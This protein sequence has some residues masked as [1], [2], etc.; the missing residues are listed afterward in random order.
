MYQEIIKLNWWL[1][2]QPFNNISQ[3]DI[4][5]CLLAIIVFVLGGSMTL[6]GLYSWN[7]SSVYSNK[8]RRRNVSFF[9][10]VLGFFFTLI[11]CGAFYIFEFSDH[12]ISGFFILILISVFG[13]SLIAV[14]LFT[15]MIFKDAT[16]KMLQKETKEK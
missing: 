12:S 15:S 14:R 6:L 16:D 10:G 7:V 1:L 8:N 5:F 11:I 13:G 4:L 2:E 9:V 3:E